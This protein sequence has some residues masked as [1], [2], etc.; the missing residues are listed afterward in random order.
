MGIGV[1]SKCG[2]RLLTGFFF[3]WWH[4]TWVHDELLELKPCFQL[5]IMAEMPPLFSVPPD[6]ILPH[7]P[8]GDV[9]PKIFCC[10][11]WLPDPNIVIILIHDND[12]HCI[13]F[14]IDKAMVNRTYLQQITYS[15]SIYWARDATWYFGVLAQVCLGWLR[16]SSQAHV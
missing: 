14:W 2:V 9:L 12:W 8:M 7:N 15:S 13:S 5:F 6:W 16:Q 11:Q 10:K 3:H 4:L 1:G